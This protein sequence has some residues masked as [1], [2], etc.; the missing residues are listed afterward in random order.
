M[1]NAV[2]T[3]RL[4]DQEKDKLNVVAAKKGWTQSQ[5]VREIVKEY[6]LKEKGNE[7]GLCNL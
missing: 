6:L 1:K 7:E 2:I 5:L 4:T 3:F